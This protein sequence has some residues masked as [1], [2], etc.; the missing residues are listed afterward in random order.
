ME[1]LLFFSRFAL[2]LASFGPQCGVPLCMHGFFLVISMRHLACHLQFLRSKRKHTRGGGESE[3]QGNGREAKVRQV[4]CCAL[5]CPARREILE[6]ERV[7]HCFC[8]EMGR[9]VGLR[10]GRHIGNGLMEVLVH[11]GGT[12]EWARRSIVSC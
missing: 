12:D 4:P 1:G 5:H 3:K 11:V 2:P 6:G 10:K 9:F 7:L 8:L